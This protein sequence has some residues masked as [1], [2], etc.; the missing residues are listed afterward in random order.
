MNNS[1][2]EIKTPACIIDELRKIIDGNKDEINQWFSSITKNSPPLFYNSVDLRHSGFKIAPVDTNVFPAG[3]N[4]L[5]PQERV[6]S[7]Q[8]VKEYLYNY[9]NNIDKILLISEE[10]TRNTFYL[11][12]IAVLKKIIEDAG[13][14]VRLSNFTTSELGETST[15]ESNSGIKLIAHPIISE[16]NVVKTKDGFVP[17]LILVN[18][19]MTDG[20][21]EMLVNAKQPV[22]PPVGFGWYQRRKTSHF[23]SYNNLAREFCKK[24]NLDDWLITT[25]F[26]KC[27]VVNFKERKGIEC[28]ALKVD[29]AI[30]RIQQKYNEYG[31]EDTPYVFVKSDRG[32]YGM[33][34][35]TVR[36]GDEVLEMNKKIRN[37][38]NTIKGGESNSEVIIQ[39]GIP[40][41]DKVDGNPAEPMMYLLGGKPVGCIYRINTKRDAY[42][43]LNASGMEFASIKGNS[44][45][46]VCS[47]LGLIAKIASCASS[48]ECYSDSYDI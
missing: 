44:Q 38:M 27:G 31:I 40:T 18:N 1:N 32:T 15:Y 45:D 37:K 12:N 48:W 9:H 28:V 36:S 39:E 5:S 11:E 14:E 42:G 33:G 2:N 47:S 35:M 7:A 19:D 3:F 8:V 29:K 24:F 4:N 34:I 16:D 41:I 6:D 30:H 23:E 46:N 26:E 43:N 22:T 20:S 13:I 10:H 25:I 21:P 17:D